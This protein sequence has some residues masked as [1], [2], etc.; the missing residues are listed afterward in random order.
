MLSNC[1][2]SNRF[3]VLDLCV[4]CHPMLIIGQ[5]KD[6]EINVVEDSM[7]NLLCFLC[8]YVCC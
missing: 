2:F 4:T 8:F 3:V 1:G 5:G 6:E 7:P